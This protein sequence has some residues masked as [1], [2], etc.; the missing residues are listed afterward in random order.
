[1]T[2][3]YNKRMKGCWR[4]GKGCKGDSEER[5]YSKLEIKQQLAED[6][7]N[8]LHKY[9]KGARTKNM[10]AR[11]EYRIRWYEELNARYKDNA[12]SVFG[13]WF[14]DGLRKAKE[15]LAKLDRKEGK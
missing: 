15:E 2:A 11:L 13:H 12:T 7:E 3:P 1:M 8:Y 10:R 4:Q 6:E 14:M 9:H 5:Q